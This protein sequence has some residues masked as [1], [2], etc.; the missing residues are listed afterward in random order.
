MA[1]VITLPAGTER[2]VVTGDGLEPGQI[3]G[4]TPDG[5]D[6]ATVG[7]GTAIWAAADVVVVEGPVFVVNLT[8]DHDVDSWAFGTLADA[9]RF[10]DGA[11]AM[12][13][14]GGMAYDVSVGE[15]QSP[16][17]APVDEALAGLR[18]AYYME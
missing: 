6:L 7:G 10:A 13:G 2:F 1:E 18:E 9:N 3:V 8:W 12:L 16:T 14:E 4:R 17:I 15:V 5:V 11:Q